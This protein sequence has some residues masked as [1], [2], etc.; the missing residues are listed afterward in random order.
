M[1]AIKAVQ[2]AMRAMVQRVGCLDAAAAIIGARMGAVPS[3]GT[4]SKKLAG[5]LDFTIVDLIA[6]E[7]ASSCFHVTTM[8][9]KRMSAAIVAP[10]CLIEE[11]AIVAREGGEAVSAILMASQ[12]NGT[13]N[14]T[15]ALVE[16]DEAIAAL[17]KV[18]ATLVSVGAP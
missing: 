6:L 9:V 7:D 3:K 2:V 16:V 10:G 5:S 12:S 13:Q 11:G 1:D 15:R 14:T 4:L 18:R 17:Q 8:L